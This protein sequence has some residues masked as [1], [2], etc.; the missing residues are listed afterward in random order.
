MLQYVFAIIIISNFNY[1]LPLSI[2]IL[3]VSSTAW[4]MIIK[5]VQMSFK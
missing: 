3:I 4:T 2:V 1:F 5:F